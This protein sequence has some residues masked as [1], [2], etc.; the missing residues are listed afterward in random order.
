MRANMSSHSVETAPAPPRHIGLAAFGMLPDQDRMAALRLVDTHVRS[1]SARRDIV[2][3]GDPT[4]AVHIL[5]DGWACRYKTLVDGRRQIVAFLIPGDLCDP[6]LSALERTDHSLGAITNVKAARIGLAEF[7]AFVDSHPAV[8]R[9]LRRSE[10]VT[11]SI[12]REW[13]LSAGARAASERIAHLM[14]EMYLRLRAFGLAEGGSCEF[15]ITQNDIADAT[16]LT[17]VHVNRMVQCLRRDG[18]IELQG[19]RL[20]IPSLPLLMNAGLFRSDYLHLAG[21]GAYPGRNG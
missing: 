19:K 1:F 21:A 15:P 18:L 6:N 3:E 2:R 4:R 10:A 17:P 5:L 11:A 8:A 13:T 12:Q 20:S 7:D 16:G 9:A 14:C